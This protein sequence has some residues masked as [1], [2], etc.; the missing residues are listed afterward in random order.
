VQTTLPGEPIGTV[1]KR[2]GV[3]FDQ[4]P[5][6][7]RGRLTHKVVA[8]SPTLVGVREVAERGPGQHFGGPEKEIQK[9]FRLRFHGGMLAR[10]G[11]Q[12]YYKTLSHMR[13]SFVMADRPSQDKNMLAHTFI[14][15]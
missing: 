3:T 13:Q 8:I 9:F 10:A 5:L 1:I 2:S 11:E 15:S 6:L 4:L 14:M 7:H 12:S